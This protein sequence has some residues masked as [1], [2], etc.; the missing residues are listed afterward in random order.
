[1]R[2]LTKLCGIMLIL[3]MIVLL[4]GCADNNR[5]LY[6]PDIANQHFEKYYAELEKAALWMKDNPN[7]WFVF[8][9]EDSKRDS[10]K[11]TQIEGYSVF[12]TNPL[13]SA[14]IEEI[15]DNVLPAF[16]DT[17][18]ESIRRQP[19]GFAEFVFFIYQRSVFDPSFEIAKEMQRTG[20][21][22]LTDKGYYTEE[23]DLQNDWY[24]VGY[25]G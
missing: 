4:C 16:S 3:I 22:Q 20:S 11:Y 1:M 24:I 18:L 8:K 25:S 17:L 10:R 5:G 9:G 2:K 23:I 19:E 15:K 6:S 12:S 14:E 21:G 13:S 7:I